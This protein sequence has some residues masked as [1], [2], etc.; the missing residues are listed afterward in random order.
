VL[1]AWNGTLFSIDLA[2]G[3]QLWQK[4]KFSQGDYR[5]PASVLVL[6]GL[7]WDMNITSKREDGRLTG[8]DPRTG[9]EKRTFAPKAHSRG[10]PTTAAIV[11]VLRRSTSLHRALVWNWW[12]RSRKSGASTSLS[13]GPVYTES[14]PPTV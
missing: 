12:I 3:K 1:F 13:A 5:S 2:T 6:D 8:F 11:A 10:W 14:C 4:G 7:V 9:E